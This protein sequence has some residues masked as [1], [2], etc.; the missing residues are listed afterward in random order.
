MLLNN[1][2]LLIEQVIDNRPDSLQKQNI[3]SKVLGHKIAASILP[4]AAIYMGGFHPVRDVIT[5]AGVDGSSNL[6][7]GLA[8][9]SG[10]DILSGGTLGLAAMGGTA[11]ANKAVNM[12]HKHKYGIEPPPDNRTGS[13]KLVDRSINVAQRVAQIGTGVA[14]RGALGLGLNALAGAGIGTG[15]AAL[16]TLS[17]AAAPALALG[18]GASLATGMMVSKPFNALKQKLQEKRQLQQSQQG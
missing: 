10:A 14:T 18:V 8:R 13:Q 3:Q 5:K 6:V 7:N 12:Y 2:D 1:I 11:L 17:A 4:S 16:G 15:A 9:F